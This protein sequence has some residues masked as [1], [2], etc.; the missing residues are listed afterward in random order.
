MHRTRYRWILLL[1]LALMSIAGAA[2][3]AGAAS[4]PGHPAAGVVAPANVRDQTNCS[5]HL[6]LSVKFDGFLGY[7]AKQL[8][9]WLPDAD[10]KGHFEFFGPGGHIANSVNRVWHINEFYEVNGLWTGN[11]GAL[12]CARFWVYNAATRHWGTISGNYCLAS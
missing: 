2:V 8:A 12:W 9:A 3:P 6:C 1:A 11:G 5:A 10:R 4:A 7:N